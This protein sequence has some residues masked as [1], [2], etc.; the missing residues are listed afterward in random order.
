MW[1]IECATEL[2]WLMSKPTYVHVP[3]FAVGFAVGTC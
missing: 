1:R 3:G 2:A